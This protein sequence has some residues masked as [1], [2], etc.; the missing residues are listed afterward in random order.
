MVLAYRSNPKSSARPLHKIGGAG[1]IANE[2]AT[3]DQ[4]IATLNALVHRLNEDVRRLRADNAAWKRK[5]DALQQRLAARG[6]RS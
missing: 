1:V 6:G 4:R 5:A 3:K 2:I